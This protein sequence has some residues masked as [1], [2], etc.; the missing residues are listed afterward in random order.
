MAQRHIGEPIRRKE[1]YRLLTGAGCYTDDLN[2]AEQLFVAFLRSPHAHARIVAIDAAEAEVAAGVVAIFTGRH[3][4]VDKVGTIICEAE[5]K[6]AAGRAMFKPV[7]PVF[8]TD[9]VR[10]V[11][12][13]IAMVVAASYEQARDAAELMTIDYEELPAVVGADA[14][15][16]DDAPLVWPENGSNLAVHWESGDPAPVDAILASSPHCVSVDVVNNRVIPSPMEPCVALAT[17]DAER[18]ITTL[19]TPFQGGR[20]LQ[21]RLSQFLS[22]DQEKIRVLAHDTGGGFGIRSSTY[23][24]HLALTWAARKMKRS[25][26]WHSDRSETFISDYHGRDQINHAEVALDREGRILAL[27]VET[28]LNLGAHLSENGPRLPMAGGGRIIP[29]A[30]DITSFYFSVKPVL[31]NTVPT[32][33]YRGA[34]RPE[35]NFLMER[36]MDSAAA[37][38][39]L[40]R[41]EIRR[42]NLIAADKLPYTTQMGLVIDSGD[43]V[44]TM[45][46]ALKAADWH[47]F[48]V[49]RRESASRG[50]MRG[51]GIASFI[52]G[53]GGQPV[54][55]MRVRLAGDGAVSVVAGTYSH[56]QGHETVYA[57]LVADFLGVSPDNVT[58]VQGDTDTMPARAVGTF[59]SRSSMMGGA[60]IRRACDQIIAK[61]KMIA[62]HLL[63][64]APSQIAFADGVFT[65]SAGSITL[66]E[67]AAAAN[68]ADS[69]PDGIA[70]GLDVLCTLQ[71]D[72]M[73]YPNGCHICELEVD[74]ETGAIELLN[75]VAVDDCGVVLNPLIVHGQVYGGVAQGLGQGL[76]EN[77]VYDSGTGQLL[78]GSY[79]DYG[80]IRASDI[81]RIHVLMNEVPCTTNDLGVKGV[82]EA[83][84][85]GA[86]HALV[87]A[88]ID[89]LRPLGISHLNMPLTPQRVWSAIQDAKGRQGSH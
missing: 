61:G 40:T 17:H 12:E 75:Y 24:E 86:P 14:A 77:L 1:D 60:G 32:E 25:L 36:L 44:G 21:K 4:A 64:A 41:D 16:R 57:Q 71:Q 83:G 88:A 42:R 82:G 73:N 15:L 2:F 63:Q 20:R 43:F 8:P 62:G 33:T 53:A 6:D 18:D 79:M 45:D 50:K 30:Y 74:P 35:A 46:M 19:Y 9:R 31:T 55:E 10:F 59:G 29:C 38:C 89:A 51:I 66:A 70:P 22:V 28:L 78:T 65:A 87:S 13:P 81:S 39:G 34:G 26:K 7:R 76:C 27:K 3:L 54:E 23:P 47:G 48:A 58:I 11:G 52:A 37:V 56:G 68:R 84:A 67:I 49:R 69:R 5:L 80:M 85:C 72:A